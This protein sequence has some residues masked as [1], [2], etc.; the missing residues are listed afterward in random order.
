VLLGLAV[1]DELVSGI[2]SVGAPDIEAALGAS[3]ALAMLV[4]FVVPGVIALLVEPRIFLVQHRHPWLVRAGCAVMA[5]GCA[6]SAIAPG[7]VSLALASGAL[8]IA[9]GTCS[10]IAQARLV[11]DAGD[12]KGR[13]MTRWTLLALAGDLL[14][15]ALL[16][17]VSWRAAYAVLAAGLLAWT[18]LLPPVPAARD[19]DDAAPPVRF[20][21][22]IRDRQ[23]VVWLAATA[24][25][26][27]LDEI[28][29]V[30]ASLHVRGAL[31]G[32]PL[33]QTA[34][35]VSF[36]AGG[37]LGLVAL[38]KLLANRDERRVLFAAAIACALAYAAWL[39]VPSAWPGAASGPAS[40]AAPWLAAA[41]M[42]PVGAFAAP[43][44]PLTA[45]QAYAQ[46]PDSPG[47][48]LAASHLFTPV[49]L[50][51]P[52]VIGLVADHAGTHVAL[53]LLVIQPLGLACLATRSASV[54]SGNAPR[55]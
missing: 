50:A 19:A 35:V 26:D 42:L 49:G 53:A 15:P 44:Y 52:F 36:M 8:F 1:F 14:A 12:A 40:G 18:L 17:V 34:T 27:L 54:A 7:A 20:R 38:D 23:L 43:L 4:L 9:I 46:R 37:A 28:L 13:V 6:V 32:S 10:G 47:A 39:G 22:A 51:L 45:A 41:L 31:G 3:H 24:L 25:C 11:A 2:S 5:A 16:A 30:F 48:V 55:A 21:D 29:I 33:A